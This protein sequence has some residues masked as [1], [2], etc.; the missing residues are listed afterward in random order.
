MLPPIYVSLDHED[1]AQV[2]AFQELVA[3]GPYRLEAHDRH[4]RDPLVDAKGRRVRLTP[5]DHRSEPLRQ[6]LRDRFNDC[7]RLLVL[8]GNTTADHPWVD[9]EIKAFF[10]LKQ[11]HAGVRTWKHIRGMRLR[12]ARGGEPSA[13]A[14]RA[15]VTLDWSPTGLTRWFDTVL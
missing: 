4:A 11:A 3:R 5:T 15:T 7:A 10:E 12:G 14:G 2:R 8:I 13:L 1:P 9:W 6:V